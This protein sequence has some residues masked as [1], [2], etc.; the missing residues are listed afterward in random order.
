MLAVPITAWVGV[1]SADM[2]R[3]REYD[4][5]ALMDTRRTSGYWYLAGIRPAR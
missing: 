1:F 2:L 4:P 3:R 5:V